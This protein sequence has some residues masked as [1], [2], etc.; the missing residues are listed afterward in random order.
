MRLG[1]NPHRTS[2]QARENAEKVSGNV[3]PSYGGKLSGLRKIAEVSAC[4]FK[5]AAKISAGL[6]SDAGLRIT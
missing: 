1:R 4:R 6:V 5:W 2:S 3:A